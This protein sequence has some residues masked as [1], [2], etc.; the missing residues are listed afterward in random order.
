[1][2]ASPSFLDLTMMSFCFGRL[3][4]LL[5]VLATAKVS[6]RSL[7][8]DESPRKNVLFLVVDDFRMQVLMLLKYFFQYSL[9]HMIN[10]HIPVLTKIQLGKNRVPHTA[11]MHT[12]NMNKLLDKSSFFP[13]AQVRVSHQNCLSR[14]HA[15]SQT[16]RNI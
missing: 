12:P 9:C 8:S 13:R 4:S 7:R 10:K 16:R 2:N 15:L 3:S 6:S 14:L 5:L 11:A 1:M